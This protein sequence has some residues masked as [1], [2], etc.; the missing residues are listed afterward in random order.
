MGVRLGFGFICASSLIEIKVSWL[1][2]RLGIR[3]KCALSLIEKKG[4]KVKMEVRVWVHMCMKSQW[5]IVVRGE[6]KVWI[7]MCRKSL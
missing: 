6:V 7:N 1:G 3:F 4:D 2:L 5:L